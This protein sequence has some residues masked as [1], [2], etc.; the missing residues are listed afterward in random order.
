MHSEPYR[1]DERN[2]SGTIRPAST[3]NFDSLCDRAASRARAAATDRLMDA[4]DE[5]RSCLPSG[6]PLSW[7]TLTAGTVLDGDPYL[8][9]GSS[10]L[11][12]LS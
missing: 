6:H 2:G 8:C 9:S 1:V 5:S 10:V 4:A 12:I 11:R 3:A 7:G